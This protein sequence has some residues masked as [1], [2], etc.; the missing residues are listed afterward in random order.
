MSIPAYSL[1][2]ALIQGINVDDYNFVVSQ[3]I[4]GPE[5]KS[6]DENSDD[7]I[8]EVIRKINEKLEDSPLTIMPFIKSCTSEIRTVKNNA[9]K[10][11][12]GWDASSEYHALVEGGSFERTGLCGIAR[13]SET[14]W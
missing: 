5:K 3:I 11:I 14:N 10:W 7:D 13:A 12:L 1:G 2:K 4:I 6:C 8:F 9:E